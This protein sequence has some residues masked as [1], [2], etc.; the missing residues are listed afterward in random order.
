M[1]SVKSISYQSISLSFII[2]KF[3]FLEM[4]KHYS[5][6]FMMNFMIMSKMI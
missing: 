3:I 4:I 2:F 5:I 1:F 6:D